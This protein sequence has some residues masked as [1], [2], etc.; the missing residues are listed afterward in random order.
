[1]V[2]GY[3][4][5]IQSETASSGLTSVISA[6]GMAS[7]TAATAGSSRRVSAS[8]ARRW[9]AWRP[10]AAEPLSRLVWWW[11]DG[12]TRT[13]VV[14]AGPTAFPLPERLSNQGRSGADCCDVGRPRI[15]SMASTGM[16]RAQP[17]FTLRSSP[18]A[19]IFATAQELLAPRRAPRALDLGRA[20]DFTVP[21][22]GH[23]FFKHHS[24]PSFSCTTRSRGVPSSASMILA[25]SAACR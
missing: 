4:I 13:R 22:Y 11:C 19:S 15:S 5:Q 12:R 23:D 3:A 18:L 25:D 17:S 8:A 7:S 1:M 6:P 24:T 14:V 21:L 10:S 2:C 20:L 9:A 16:R